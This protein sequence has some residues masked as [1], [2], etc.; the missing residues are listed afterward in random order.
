MYVSQAV[1]GLEK[2]ECQC[3][4]LLMHNISPNLFLLVVHTTVVKLHYIIAFCK[5]S[6]PLSLTVP[7]RLCAGGEMNNHTY[8]SHMHSIFPFHSNNLPP[9]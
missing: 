4:D 2:N 9:F 1:L 5:D 3:T 7:K 6:L 8:L